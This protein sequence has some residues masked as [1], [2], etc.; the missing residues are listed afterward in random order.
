MKTK[1][2]KET[3]YG[4][5]IVICDVSA[6]VI[7]QGTMVGPAQPVCCGSMHCRVT[8][9]PSAYLDIFLSPDLI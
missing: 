9:M 7:R 5:R 6:P 2:L 4:R 1:K 3:K 8:R